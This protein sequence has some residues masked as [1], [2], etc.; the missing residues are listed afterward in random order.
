MKSI[1]KIPLLLK[2]ENVC[3]YIDFALVDCLLTKYTLPTE[4]AP[5]LLHLSQAMRAGHLCVKVDRSAVLPKP[6][7][8]WEI[9][10]NI[11]LSEEE[12]QELEYLISAS[13]PNFPPSFL[14]TLTLDSKDTLPNTPLCRFENLFYYQ[15]YWIHESSCLRGMHHLLEEKPALMLDSSKIQS[16]L[17]Q[18]LSKNHLLPE[19]AKAITQLDKQSLT[20]I[21]GGPGTGKTYTAGLLIKVFWNA[22]SP[23]D[24]EKCRIFLAAPTGKAAANLQ[25]SLSRAIGEDPNFPVITATTLHS[26]LGIKPSTHSQPNLIPADLLIIDEC[27][28]IDIRMMSLL[29]QA[30]KPGARL[31]LLGDPNQL[32]P[33]DAGSF[34]S[35]MI[36]LCPSSQVT[37]LQTCLR[38]ELKEIV[39]LAESVK[40]GS[41]QAALHLFQTSKNTLFFT[42]L[43][44]IQNP[45]EIQ[46]KLWE[47]AWPYL[48]LGAEMFQRFCILS[49]LRKGFLGVDQL[50]HFFY[51]E[52][53]KNSQN[54]SSVTIP[55]IIVANDPKQG[56]FNGDVGILVR[57]KWSDSDDHL[58]MGDYAV[59]TDRKI[60]ALLLPRYEYA[61]CLSVHKSQG[62]EFDRLILLIPEG[63]E[64]FGRELVYTGITRARKQL[65]IWSTPFLFENALSH[66]SKRLS[67]RWINE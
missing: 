41:C 12:W 35:D 17:E 16:S 26:L 22:L 18:F 44:E 48:K 61:F 66:S 42:S 37:E 57:Q 60:P 20:I 14:T 34:F 27:S 58:R 54:R 67:R 49:P 52:V 59:F 5:L 13:I 62:S 23:I 10:E 31:V 55:I 63:S 19:Q 51:K 53:I 25:K 24:R 45:S 33:I 2:L 47:V 56:L 1:E 6:K 8:V 38:A 7:D 65:E 46:H 39:N 3:P 50:N 21:Y 4:A 43:A 32:P 64:H 30:L 9:N 28:M 29:F 36:H 15:K 40:K 11:K